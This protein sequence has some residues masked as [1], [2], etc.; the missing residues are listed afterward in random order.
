MYVHCMSDD[1]VDYRECIYIL[2]MYVQMVRI[3]LFRERNLIE[4]QINIIENVRITILINN[5]DTVLVMLS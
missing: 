4:G 3:L 1:G 2:Y 5:Y